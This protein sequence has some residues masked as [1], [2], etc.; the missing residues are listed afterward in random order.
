MFK[1]VSS[2]D[3]FSRSAVSTDGGHPWFVVQDFFLSCSPWPLEAGRVVYSKRQNFG[4]VSL[5]DIQLFRVSAGPKY[6]SLSV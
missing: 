6:V 4:I 3:L 1:S 5:P 2:I